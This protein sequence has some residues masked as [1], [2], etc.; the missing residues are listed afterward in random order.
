MHSPR[1][2][3]LTVTSEQAGWKVD[4]LLRGPLALSGTVIRRAKRLEAGILLDGV[5]AAAGD[6]VQ[7]G[8]LLSVV[9]GDTAVS[10]AVVPAPG[11]LDIVYQDQ[12]VLVLNKAPGVAVHPGP[13]HHFDTIGNFL[14]DYYRKQGI[15]ADF[16]PVHRL[17]RGTSGLLLVA[18]HS[19][20]QE[21]LRLQLH[22]PAFRRIYLA[23]CEGVPEP[24]SGVIDAPIG[25]L[26]GSVLARTVRPD[27]QRA[28]TRYR[29]L[30]TGDGRALL[31]LE[32]E[33]GR[34]HQIRVHL[35]H[36]GHP[37]TGDF[38]YGTE[39]PS[40]IP[41]PALHAAELSFTHPIT[42]ASMTFAAPLPQDMAALVP[43]E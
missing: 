9:V 28:V 26:E 11:S 21:A 13:G 12:D 22:T 17:D 32:L 7:T 25:R 41:R 4:A 20:A 43:E 38:L 1:R 39:D 30:R 24:P 37:L 18:L 15:L 16:H 8:Q 42:G 29:T 14:M 19:H 33:T 10:G 6:R 31:R 5:R 35:A 23:V 2:L 34:T 3:S 27:G 40:L 36:V